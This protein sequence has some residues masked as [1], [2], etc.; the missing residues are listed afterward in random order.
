MKELR[1][2]GYAEEDPS[3]DGKGKKLRLTDNSFLKVEADRVKDDA[4][5]TT[6]LAEKITE[7]AALIQS[8]IRKSKKRKSV[9]EELKVKD[10]ESEEVPDIANSSELLDEVKVEA[11]KNKETTTSH[12]NNK[13][14][15]IKH[16]EYLA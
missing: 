14:Q 4:I 12:K 8:R 3:H 7:G 16:D 5:D 15:R 11:A 6:K 2:K 1:E 9:K 10:E 13:R